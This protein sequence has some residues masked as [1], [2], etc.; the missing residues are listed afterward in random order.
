MLSPQEDERHHVRI[1]ARFLKSIHSPRLE[2][3]TVVLDR[4]RSVQVVGSWDHDCFLTCKIDGFEL[5]CRERIGGNK[6][7]ELARGGPYIRFVME[8]FESASCRRNIPPQYFF[9]IA[10]RVVKIWI[11][12]DFTGACSRGN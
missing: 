1:G 2:R 4:E 5:G 12:T 6:T 7:R 3:T 11:S 8:S 10:F 9:K